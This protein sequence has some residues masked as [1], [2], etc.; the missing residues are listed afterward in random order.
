[1]NLLNLPDY[2]ISRV[3]QSARDYRV[4]A[5]YK[6]EPDRC[7]HCGKGVLFGGKLYRHGS[8]EQ[9][10]M[11]LPA[12]GKRVG[13]LLTRNRYRCQDCGKTF[14]QPI[15]D[16][17]ERS[18]MTKRLA[19]YIGEQSI[20]RTFASVADDVGVDEKTVRNL[21]NEYIDQLD[22]ETAF[23]TPDWLGID[24]VHLLRKPRCVLTN[25][26]DRTIIGVLE[27]RDKKSVVAHLSHMENNDLVEV[28]TMDM[29]R[30]YLD[31]VGLT[32]PKAAVVID[33]FHVVRMANQCLEDV[34]KSFRAGLELKA[35]RQLMHDRFVLLRREADLKP[36]QRQKLE[37]WAKVFPLLG[38]AHRVKEG[39]FRIYDHTTRAEAEAAFVA[40]EKSIP[41]NLLMPF[42]PLL[43]AVYNWKATI[44][45]YF[46]HRATNA[47]TEALNGIAKNIER[48]G[49]GYSFKAIR[50]KMLYSKGLQKQARPVR[51]GGDFVG[52][53]VG[54]PVDGPKP[55]LGTDV[56]ALLRVLEQE[57]PVDG[58]STR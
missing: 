54:C 3:E 41:H 6:P 30:P 12:H 23:V 44:F 36:E 31:A 48:L 39:F 35:R 4:H 24:E 38:E 29:W 28:V 19:A 14:L 18:Q 21:F 45:N 5:T 16:A 20:V 37:S 11:D 55:I 17:D 1:M 52:K 49:R 2:D 47:C 22:L 27:K 8:R 33:K 15:P 42:R 46:D 7:I 51:Y 13:V 9:L 58:E 50:A 10:L 53:M 57:R 43:T 56:D 40:W 25:V 34:R 32:M 26:K